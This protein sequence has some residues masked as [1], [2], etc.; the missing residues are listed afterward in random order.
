V[1]HAY[2][3]CR[4]GETLAGGGK[5]SASVRLECDRGALDLTLSLDS[6]GKLSEARFERPPDVPCVP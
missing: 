3:S 5:V 4:A 6:D 1:R 2:G